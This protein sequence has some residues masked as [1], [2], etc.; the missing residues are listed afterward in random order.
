MPQLSELIQSSTPPSSMHAAYPM[1]YGMVPTQ[2]VSVLAG[3]MQNNAAIQQVEAQAQIAP[4]IVTSRAAEYIADQLRQATEKLDSV[5]WN[6]HVLDLTAVLKHPK[7]GDFEH[8]K[9]KLEP[10]EP[11]FEQMHLLTALFLQVLEKHEHRTLEQGLVPRD[12]SYDAN[13]PFIYAFMDELMKWWQATTPTARSPHQYLPNLVKAT[14]AVMRQKDAVLRAL[15]SMNEV[16]DDDSKWEPPRNMFQRAW[17]FV[18]YRTV[19]AL[20]SF[21]V[22]LLTATLKYVAVENQFDELAANFLGL[23]SGSVMGS[24]SAWLQVNWPDVHHQ[25]TNM[26]DSSTSDTEI[27]HAAFRQYL[28]ARGFLYLADYILEA[29][30]LSTAYKGVILALL[31]FVFETTR[32]FMD[33]PTKWLLN[34]LLNIVQLTRVVSWADRRLWSTGIMNV[35]N[36]KYTCSRGECKITSVYF[37]RPDD[38]LFNTKNECL[39]ACAAAVD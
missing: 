10:F 32:M 15:I 30:N 28:L 33:Y 39:Q 23:T 3:G 6:W 35:N 36:F 31:I 13:Y 17:R 24:V 22:Y 12:G 21:A 19:T 20:K 37:A 25:L 1:G 14:E 5:M 8:L 34:R 2:Q 29:Y 4:Y 27:T 26:L 16:L 9:R 11:Q 38:T 7:P 18:M